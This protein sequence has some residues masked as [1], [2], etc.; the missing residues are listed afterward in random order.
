MT[1]GSLQTA[2]GPDVERQ[3]RLGAGEEEDDDELSNEIRKASEGRNDRRQASGSMTCEGRPVGS[4]EIEGG[5]GW[6]S[7]WRS[8]CA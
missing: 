8:G 5:F 7:I 2:V 6:F 3:C 4:A 1:V